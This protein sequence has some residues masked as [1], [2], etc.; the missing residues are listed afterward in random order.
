M[1]FC[2]Y[3]LTEDIPFDDQEIKTESD[4]ILDSFNHAMSNWVL[5]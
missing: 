2:S 4:L 3:S 1:Q 5:N